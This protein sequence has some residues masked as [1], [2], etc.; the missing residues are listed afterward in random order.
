MHESPLMQRLRLD[1][2]PPVTDLLLTYLPPLTLVVILQVHEQYLYLG[3][4][5]SPAEGAPAD[6]TRADGL[7]YFVT[8]IPV[9]E[10]SVYLR[11]QKVLEQNTSI[12]KDLILQTEL[13]ESFAEHYELVMA[14]VDRFLMTPVTQM[15]ELEFF[16]LGAYAEHPL[17]PKQIL[18]LPDA[19]LSHFP[20]ERLPSTISLMGST[21]H[22]AF[23]RDLSLHLFAQRVRGHV[24][25]E[26]GP[27]QMQAEYKVVNPQAVTLLTDPFS[28]DMVRP[29]ED[30]TSE[31]MC[32]VHK[33]LEADKVIASGIHGDMY[34]ASPQD[35]TGMFADAS[36]FFF[37]GFGRF[38]TMLPASCMSSEDLRH[39][40]L[41]VSFGRSINDLAFRR[42]TKTDS[43]KSQKQLAAESTYGLMLMAGFRGVQCIV[44][45]T[46]P[47]PIAISMRTAETFIRA[48][49]S[50]KSTAKS[51]EE[52]LNTET[53]RP[54]LRYLRNV[55]GGKAP[56][57][58]YVPSG[59][60]RTDRSSFVSTH[61]NE[62][63]SPTQGGVVAKEPLLIFHSRSAFVICGVPWVSYGAGGAPP[64]GKK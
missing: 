14:E 7:R 32:N 16:P 45:A 51:L 49:H 25:A 64:P 4:A 20:L 57:Q 6:G 53:D 9:D 26:G 56:T 60:G 18:L 30:P 44:M 11:A 15:L 1:E 46:S 2:L 5:C 3:A 12:E 35:I 37:L 42:Q 38:F 36:A 43:M 33:R 55:E 50:G 17:N 22:S 52:C 48:M 61:P 47:V 21:N 28:E 41:L 24:E 40:S 8:R 34:T 13:N 39:L 62:S 29:S 63:S 59:E 23:A 19:T 54:D 10:S 27:H 31:R 58:R